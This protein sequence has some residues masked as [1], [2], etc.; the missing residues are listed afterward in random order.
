MHEA[1]REV[2][3]SAILS[4]QVPTGIIVL[5]LA[6]DRGRG[7][8]L[9]EVTLLPITGGKRGKATNLLTRRFGAGA[10]SESGFHLPAGHDSADDRYFLEFGLHGEEPIAIRRL[11]VEA[12]IPSSFGLSLDTD[13]GGVVA[14]SVLKGGAGEKA[15]FKAGDVLVSM[16]GEKLSDV[17]GTLR[18]L[19]EAPIGEDVTFVVRRSGQEKTIVVKGE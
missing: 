14:K 7:D 13:K 12:K 9:A 18:R 16:G 17:K 5:N 19:A 3:E 15:G 2:I 1:N 6:P 10:V 8:I 11:E 4:S